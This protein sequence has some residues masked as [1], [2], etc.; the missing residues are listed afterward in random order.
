MQNKAG[1]SD[2]EDELPDMPEGE[3]VESSAAVK[4]TAA[5][6]RYSR[7]LSDKILI[8][9]HQACDQADYDVAK[10]LLQ[11]FEYMLSRRELPADLNRRRNQE[12]LI[13]AHERLWQLCHP[14]H[15]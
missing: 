5:A 4:D 1:S 8:S 3:G 13:A 15:D 7:R 6:P 2:T 12:S 11:I 10:R 9:F 14:D